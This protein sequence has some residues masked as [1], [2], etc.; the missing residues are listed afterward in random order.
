[1]RRHWRNHS[2]SAPARSDPDLGRGGVYHSHHHPH[3]ARL[4]G[5]PHHAL[6]SPPAT[7]SSVSEGNSDDDGY[8]DEEDLRMDVDAEDCDVGAQEVDDDEGM[9][10]PHAHPPPPPTGMKGSAGSS[11]SSEDVSAWSRSASPARGTAY[12]PQ[13]HR[14]TPHQDQQGR[15]PHSHS[16]SHTHAHGH[17]QTSECI[18]KPS[19]AAY[20]ISSDSRV[21]TALRPAFTSS[22]SC[23][24][25]DRSD[26]YHARGG[27]EKRHGQGYPSRG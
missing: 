22:S 8:S 21:S 5:L 3:H 12:G 24:A 10:R 7:N 6:M 14:H 27:R 25:R 17:G 11:S 13:L 23:S 18:Y 4:D 19:I 15:P 2:R 16:Q 1:M 9:R 20:A 26:R